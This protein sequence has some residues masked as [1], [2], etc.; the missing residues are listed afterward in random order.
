MTTMM[1]EPMETDAVGAADAAVS[2]ADNGNDTGHL[3]AMRSLWSRVKRGALRLLG[4]RNK[5]DPNEY[6]R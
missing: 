5:N 3:R 6:E 2:M 4:G 1:T